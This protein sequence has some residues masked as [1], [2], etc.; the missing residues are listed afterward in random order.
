MSDREKA[1]ALYYQQIAHRYHFGTQDNEVIDPVKVFNVYGYN[2]CGNDSICMAGL[3]KGVGLKVCPARLMGHCISQVFYDGRWHLMDGD[4]HSMYLLRDNRTIAGEQDLVRDHDLIKRSHTHGILARDKRA[5]DE[6]EAALYVYEG[7]PKGDRRCSARHTMNM[8]LRPNEA[9]TWRW[10]HLE[11]A[12]YHGKSPLKYP[13]TVCNG[14]WQYRPDF[15]RDLWR[16][17]GR[18]GRGNHDHQ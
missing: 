8:V 12:K 10:G 11:P 2:T 13:D 6:W 7:E 14:L 1:I 4:M 17:G 9:L 3:W 5:T 18:Y 15:A 16:R